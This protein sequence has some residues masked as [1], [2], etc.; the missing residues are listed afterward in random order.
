MDDLAD[1]PNRVDPERQ[2]NPALDRRADRNSSSGLE[3]YPRCAQVPCIRRFAANTDKFG[4]RK[5]A[6]LSLRD[7][8]IICGSL[9]DS[10]A[11][12]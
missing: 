1:E 6:A 7:A 10:L 9:A 11:A 4:N 5:Q 2:G 8:A 12:H 3:K